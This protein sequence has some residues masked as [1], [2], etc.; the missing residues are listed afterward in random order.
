MSFPLPTIYNEFWD[1][2]QKL[3]ILSS[4]KKHLN[5]LNITLNPFNSMTL[6]SG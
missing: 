6:H 1:S 3:I 4:G 5:L 2:S